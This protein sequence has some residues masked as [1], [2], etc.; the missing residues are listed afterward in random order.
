MIAHLE[1]VGAPACT[2]IPRSSIALESFLPA[3]YGPSPKDL[4]ALIAE[5][6]KNSYAP[7]QVHIGADQKCSI[8]SLNAI[9][10]R[11]TAF[12]PTDGLIVMR[13]NLMTPLLLSYS[14]TIFWFVAALA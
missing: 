13:K 8:V 7:I 6:D 4:L 2:S 12:V 9:R 3:K 14:F 5:F 11:R 1:C 10:N